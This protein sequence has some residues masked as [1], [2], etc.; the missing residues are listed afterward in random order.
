MLSPFFHFLKIKIQNQ[1]KI[2][3]LKY[4]TTTSGRP[5]SWLLRPPASGSVK[6]LPKRFLGVILA[7]SADFGIT[8][9][10]GDEYAKK[11][12][13]VRLRA[14]SFYL[15]NLYLYGTSVVQCNLKPR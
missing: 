13:L 14:S 15:Q 10:K 6:P 8:T 7:L 5:L 11:A 1:Q 3:T 4:N 12:L 9:P 2:I